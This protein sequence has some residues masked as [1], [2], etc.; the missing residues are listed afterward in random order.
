M[1]HF[2][3]FCII[4]INCLSSYS[5]DYS[6][7]DAQSGSVPS[8]LKTAD[9][10]ARYLT[11][12]LTSPFEKTRAIYFW[13]SNN[14]NYDVAQMNS[15]DNTYSNPQELVDAVL[16]KRKGVCAHYAELFNACCKS[17]GLDSYVIM[18]YTITDKKIATL[19]HAWNA[20]RIDSKFYNFDATW[21]AGSLI[22]GKFKR[23]FND[24]FCLISPADFIKT[25]IPFD[26]IWQFIDNPLSSKEIE[27][28]DFTKLKIHSYFNYTDSIKKFSES[29]KLEKLVQ[30]N[31]RMIK[32][33]LTNNLIKD[34]KIY[35][36]KA[37]ATEKFNVAVSFFNKAVES[38]NLYVTS[39]NNQINKK[40]V[41][42]QKLI[43]LL[44]PVKQQIELTEKTIQSVN[45]DDANINSQI[46]GLEISI[47]DMKKSIAEED[48][49]WVKYRNRFKSLRI[50]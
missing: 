10:I 48:S 7:V 12:N 30:E 29:G 27:S 5:I 3:L 19:A 23:Y 2:L 11:R 16:L 14:I 38:F 17:V 13:I 36:Q 21:A 31:Q 26:P 9:E 34:H 24:Q 4:L 25:H 18:G 6:K 22:N 43:S 8:N 45:S 35:L 41:D 32:F 39:K 44:S 1:K 28:G 47:D 20:V 33:G 37:I 15:K 49:F 42:D 40:S 50:F 46:R